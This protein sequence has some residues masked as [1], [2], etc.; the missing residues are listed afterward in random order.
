LKVTPS[1]G[2][3]YSLHLHCRIKPSNHT[4]DILKSYTELMKPVFLLNRVPVP[5]ILS[6]LWPILKLREKIY[7]NVKEELERRRKGSGPS[8]VEVAG[9]CCY[10]LILIENFYM[11]YNCFFLSS[12]GWDWV[13][14]YCSHYWL[15]VL[16]PDDRRWW[17]WR[18]WRNKDW[19]GKPKYLEKTWPSATLSTTNPSWLDP[20]SNPC[21][22]G[23]K[24]ATNRLSYGVALQLF[25]FNLWPIYWLSLVLLSK[26]LL[27][28]CVCI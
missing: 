22:R 5:Q 23:G 25:Y 24:P 7:P 19:Q 4:C 20:S 17:L 8:Q 2:G 27:G 26:W 1:F 12:V 11:H 10:L 18:N 13:S 28:C 15:I 9:L 21:R 3:T 16:A 14:W 6:L